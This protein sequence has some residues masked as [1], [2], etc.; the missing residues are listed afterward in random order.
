MNSRYSAVS[1]EYLSG[2]GTAELPR[3]FDDR[4]KYSVKIR[5]G[6]SDDGKDLTR[7]SELLAHL[8]QL[9]GQPFG[10]GCYLRINGRVLIDRLSLIAL[11][12]SATPFAEITAE[13]E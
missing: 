12:H 3:G 6:S 7:R 9:I 1:Q 5:C 8:G 10:L 13:T 4:F 2:I 11:D